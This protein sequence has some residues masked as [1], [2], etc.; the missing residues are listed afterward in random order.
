MG[1]I[2]LAVIALIVVLAVVAALSLAAA[3]MHA[4]HGAPAPKAHAA[5]S[6]ADVC[7][8]C[9]KP[10]VAER[11]VSLQQTGEKAE[12]QYRCI[13][14]ALVAARD[15][16]SGDLTLR[17]RS[18][19]GGTRVV[20]TRTKGKWSASP[21]TAVV[22][23]APEAKGECIDQ[24]VVL[25]NETEAKAYQR[26]HRASAGEATFAATDVDRI[27]VAGRGPLPKEATCPVSGQ[28]VHPNASTRWTVY[29][30]KTYYFCCAGCEPRFISNADGYAS[31]TAPKMRMMEGGTCEGHEASGQKGHQRTPDSHHWTGQ[32]S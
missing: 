8:I 26:S 23:M 30:G 27:L 13:N 4:G 16:Y 11:A 24:H 25:A 1:R 17:T 3:Q 14:C 22:L 18:A 9:G 15:W 7:A 6:G 31:G 28:K 19:A 21:S 29:K 2:R 32:S 5:A 10:L 12:R 20:L